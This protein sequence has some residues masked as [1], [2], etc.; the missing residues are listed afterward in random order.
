MLQECAALIFAGRGVNLE[1][2]VNDFQG[3]NLY[4]QGL[5]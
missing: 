3:R 2:R 1:E 5:L 4:E